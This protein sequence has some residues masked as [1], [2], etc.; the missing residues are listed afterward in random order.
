VE[1]TFRQITEHLARSIHAVTPRG[2]KLKVF[3]TILAYSILR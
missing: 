1:T 2:F 3:L